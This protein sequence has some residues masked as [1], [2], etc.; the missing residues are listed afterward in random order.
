MRIILYVADDIKEHEKA[1][2]FV[3]EAEHDGYFCFTTFDGDDIEIKLSK[4]Q[5]ES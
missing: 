4:A 2:F 5:I 3:T 1:I